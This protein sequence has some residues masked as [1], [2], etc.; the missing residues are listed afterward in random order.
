[1][2]DGWQANPFAK[3]RCSNCGQV[4]QYR[5]L[6]EYRC[7]FCGNEELDDYGKIR[8]Y[9]DEHGPTPGTVIEQE[10]GVRLSVINSYLRRGKLE[11]NDNSPIFIRCEICGK[12]IKFGRVCAACAKNKVSKMRDPYA[13]EEIGDEP[14]QQAFKVKNDKM[15]TGRGKR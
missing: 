5:S 11:I 12:D 10:T 13:K 9:L 4:M 2:N 7:P 15:F 8:Q 14:S 3:R 1:M 6:G